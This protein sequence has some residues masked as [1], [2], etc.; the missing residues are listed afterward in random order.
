MMLGRKKHKGFSMMEVLVT[1][2]IMAV[3]LLGMASLQFTSLKNLNSS[4]FRYQ[5]A[6]LAY[7]MSERMLAN[8]GGITAGSYSALT[9]DGTETAVSCTGGCGTAAIASLDAYEWGQNIVA[10]PSGSGSVSANGNAFDIVVSWTEQHTG[11]S[12]SS[13]GATPDAKT[14]TLTVNF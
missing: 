13:V 4:Y 8:R 14:Y 10:L 3:G 2:I 5:A 6:M 12:L 11:A 9:V 7:D 1:I